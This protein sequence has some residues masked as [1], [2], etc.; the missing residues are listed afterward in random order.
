MLRSWRRYLVLVL[1]LLALGLFFYKF[2][3]SI[4]LEG[5]HWSMVGRSLREARLSLLLVSIAAIYVCYVLRALRWIRF[6]R[7]LGPSRFPSVYKSTLIGFTCVFLLGRVGEPI[8]P[9]LIAR[10]ESLSIPGMFGVY[11]LER[12]ADMACTAVI[13]I[14]ALLVFRGRGLSLDESGPIL[15][16]A[17]LGGAAL[18][19][20]LVCIVSFLVYFRFHGSQWLAAR[21]RRPEWNSGWRASLALK[22]EG[23]SEGLQG[24]RTWNDL[25]VLAGYSAA[26]WI[27]VIFVYLWIA[28]AFGGDFASLDFGAAMLILAFTLVGSAVQLPGVGGGAQLACFLVFTLIF[29]VE[30]EPA[31]VV[32]I[33]L[34]LITFAG[35]CLVGLPL[36]LMEGWS[37]G[38]LRRVAAADTRVAREEEAEELHRI[39]GDASGRPNP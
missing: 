25:G 4:T 6:S 3:N 19:I 23:F 29:G 34:W 30:K 9:V 2:R 35:V 15:K 24:I 39:A 13:A 16:V 10:R 20:A 11:I 14:T 5:F 21:M 7:A 27:L 32:S 26:H 37:I 12:V 38:E 31:A 17:R 8:R 36:L 22:L 18:F 33:I 28:R 1:A